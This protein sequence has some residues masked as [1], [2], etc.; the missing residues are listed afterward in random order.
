MNYLHHILE[1]RLLFP[2]I[3]TLA[4]F[5]LVFR[6]NKM[7]RLFEHMFIGLAAGYS[8]AI[9]WTD[10]LKPF[11]WDPMWVDGQ[12]EWVVIVPLSFMFYAIY[13]KKFVW[14]S[15]LIF[16]FFF[17]TAS[18][19]VFRQF[20][21]EYIPQITA[22]YKNVFPDLKHGHTAMLASIPQAIDNLIFV[23]ILLAVATYFFFAFEQQNKTVQKVALSGRAILMIA[24]GAIFGATIM[25]REALLI[26][27]MYF[28]L[29]DWLQ[30]VHSAM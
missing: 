9:T 29:H 22:S 2:A 23:A 25:T 14:M 7:Y 1:P 3:G 13:T 4:I 21:G 19:T 11:W 18:G 20:A 15:R 5:S 12:W 24:L 6:E 26:D 10:V 16:G 30:I 28:L 17:G 8:L 27:R